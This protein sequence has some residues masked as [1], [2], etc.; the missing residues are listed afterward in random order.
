[1]KPIKV[2]IG[3]ISWTIDFV[4]PKDNQLLNGEFGV[5][6]FKSATIYIDKDLKPDVMKETLLH[7]LFHAIMWES[8]YHNRLYDLLDKEYETFVDITSKQLHSIIDLTKRG[9]L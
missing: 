3:N 6:I 5:T 8:S 2:K 4:S 9:V 1:M 7:E